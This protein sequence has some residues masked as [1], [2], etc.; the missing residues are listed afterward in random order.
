MNTATELNE[1]AKQVRCPACGAR[2]GE[3][4]QGLVTNHYARYE[5][6][7]RQAALSGLADDNSFTLRKAHAWLGSMQNKVTGM[8]T[9]IT[10][11][12]K[13]RDQHR[14]MLVAQS[15]RLDNHHHRIDKWRSELRTHAETLDDLISRVS[16]LE[17]KVVRDHNARIRSLE[18]D[19][20][21]VVEDPDPTPAHGIGRP[22]V[23]EDSPK[24]RHGVLLTEGDRVHLVG[25]AGMT[26][27]IEAVHHGYRSVGVRWDHDDFPGVVYHRANQLVFRGRG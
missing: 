24:D 26:G 13:S 11:L 15:K 21:F 1:R 5:E 17:A 22:G 4:C 6:A 27:K 14:D 19:A 18:H 8:S 9:S 2:P 7:G 20:G 16:E 3:T 25:V 23:T 10:Q 12:F